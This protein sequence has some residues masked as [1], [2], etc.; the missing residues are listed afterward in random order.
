MK[1]EYDENS[2]EAKES[3]S[4]KMSTHKST[5][6]RRTAEFKKKLKKRKN[7]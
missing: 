2:E 5:Y 4:S 6:S 3:G 7:G 1:D